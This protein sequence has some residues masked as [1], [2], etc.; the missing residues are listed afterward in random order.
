MDAVDS[1]VRVEQLREGDFGEWER[2]VRESPDATV[3]ALPGYLAALCEAAGGRYA[4]LGARR[5]DELAGG[6]AL[7]ESDS[8]YG[9]FV[10][11]RL[12]LYYNGPVLRR[13][14]THYPSEQT[15]RHLK[16]LGALERAI[17]QRRYARVTLACHPTFGDARP[18]LAAG[19]SAA[20]QYTY[21]VAIDDPVAQWR[22]VEQ[23]LRRLVQR[24]EREGMQCRSDDGFDA[25]YTLHARTMER[26]QRDLYL[27]APAFQRYFDRLRGAGLCRLFHARLPDGRLVASQLVLLGPQGRCHLAAAA[28]DEAFLRSGASAFLRWKSF[29]AL[30]A[31]GY[32][33]A[34]LTDAALNP[35]THF[36]SQL[37]GRLELALVLDAPRTWPYRL[38]TR[39][40][41][42][43]RRT[44]AAVAGLARRFR[45]ADRSA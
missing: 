17:S 32:A 36:K 40:G 18:F 12:L 28:T 14:D 39:A 25:F 37:G 10:A 34:D 22:R 5:G 21:I 30:A 15:A 6:V 45:R 2:L 13:Y 3:Y 11:P 38:G 24:C 31:A 44:R 1:E 35:V 23:N 42:V 20:P 43:F 27:P 9:P 4:V 19:W 41:T 8:R 26:K 33:F 16:T 7:Y 29:E